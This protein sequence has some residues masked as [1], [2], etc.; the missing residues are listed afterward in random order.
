MLL[1]V[2]LHKTIK[3]EHPRH[4]PRSRSALDAARRFLIPLNFPALTSFLFIIHQHL[5]D[6]NSR[7]CWIIVSDV[8]VYFLR[9]QGG[10]MV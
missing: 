9:M 8:A 2:K 5:G 3:E 10:L 7:A 4:C 1:L 6:F